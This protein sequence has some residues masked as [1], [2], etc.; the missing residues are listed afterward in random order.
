M[1]ELTLRYAN[2]GVEVRHYV[3]AGESAENVTRGFRMEESVI[4]HMDTHGLFMSPWW[5]GAPDP[6]NF[7]RS[8]IYDTTIRGNVMHDLGFRTDLDNAVG[9]QFEFPDRLV[10]EDN[11]I[12]N[13][14]HNGVQFLWSVIDSERSYEFAPEEIK[15][16]DLLI[17]D[18]VIERACQLTT[19]CGAI[20]FW[21]PPPHTHVFRDVLIVGNILRDTAGWTH[22]LEQRVAWWAGGAGCEV[23]GQA[24]F[25]LYLD[26]AS[27]IHAHRNIIYNNAHAGIMLVGTW[28]DGDLVLTQNILAN[29]LY[30]VRMSG[31]HDDTHGGSVNTQ[32]INN[33]IVGNEGYGIYQCTA[34]ETFG[35]LRID[36]NLYFN[37]GWRAYADGGVSQP[38][39]MA[40]NTPMGRKHYPTLGQVQGH[41]AGWEAHG[42]VGDPH[43]QD[44]DVDDHD[45]Y[46]GARPDFRL[47]AT[48][49]AIV[50][51]ADTLPASL[52][53]LLIRFD[54]TEGDRVSSAP[55]AQRARVSTLMLQP[56]L[57]YR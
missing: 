26:Y 33:I 35:N 44:Y 12:Y 1:R 49:P 17:K 55:R 10:F 6:A 39:L 41:P 29:S 5:G 57:W 28:R 42:V 53:A 4:A 23:S 37:N 24:G 51:R 54:L 56:T 21:G 31:V 19:D 8:G 34:N 47:T 27:G 3:R 16:G 7:P 25:G 50:Q 11:H 9:V 14:A 46:N 20:K 13:V 32:L 30:G 22:I 36:H 40:I 45:P 38:G 48:T 43:F 18:N 2:R 15:T 52:T